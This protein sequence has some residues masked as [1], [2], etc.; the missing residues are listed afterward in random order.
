MQYSTSL[1]LLLAFEMA[2]LM[3]G[4]VVT[5][6]PKDSLRSAFTEGILWNM[7]LFLC[8]CVE[9]LLFENL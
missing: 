8:I 1:A 7:G 2:I 3:G 5:R 6:M 4:I 9:I